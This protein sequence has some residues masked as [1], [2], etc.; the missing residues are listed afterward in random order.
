ME[1]RMFKIQKVAR[2]RFS[3]LE[4]MIGQ[5]FPDTTNAVS[6]VD[7]QGNQNLKACKLKS[8]DSRHK[9]GRFLEIRMRY[10]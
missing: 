6:N 4:D 2:S 3:R 9:D 5:T 1:A 10:K 8:C 7:E